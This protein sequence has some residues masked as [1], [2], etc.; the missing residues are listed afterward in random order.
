MT[1]GQEWA[2]VI[3]V[4]SVVLVGTFVWAL[5][6]PADPEP[7][8]V[9]STAGPPCNDAWSKKTIEQANRP[10]RI[11]TDMAIRSDGLHIAVVSRQWAAMSMDQ[12]GINWSLRPTAP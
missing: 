2:I 12:R 10:P 4:I 6:N 11:I 1:K 9:A 8:P 5:N 3:G 7:T